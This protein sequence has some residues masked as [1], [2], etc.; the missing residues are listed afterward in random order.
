MASLRLWREMA[1]KAMSGD[2]ARPLSTIRFPDECRRGPD[3]S[4]YI[5]QPGVRQIAVRRWVRMGS[6][7]LVAGNGA[8]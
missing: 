3:G 1:L 4:L 7:Q 6:L 5:A 2:V 8:S